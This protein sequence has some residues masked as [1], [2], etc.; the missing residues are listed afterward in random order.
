MSR[1]VAVH[2][3]EAALLGQAAAGDAAAVRTLLGR[4]GQQIWNEIDRDIGASWRA[5]LDADD[6]MQVTYVEAFLQMDRLAAR[7]AAGFV[8][9]L[10]RIAQNNLRDAIKEMQHS[11]VKIVNS[12]AL[13]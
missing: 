2:G 7:D 10:R 3:D 13:A 12:S 9:W 1:G 4:H 8:G 6:V 11:G 5:V